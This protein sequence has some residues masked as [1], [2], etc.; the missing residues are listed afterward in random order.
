MELATEAETQRFLGGLF[1]AWGE[2]ILRS[3]S[4]HYALN[5]EQQETLELILLKP[6]NWQLQVKAPLAPLAPLAHLRH[7]DQP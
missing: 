7:L 5:K 4:K 2:Q 3:I 6:N 1:Y